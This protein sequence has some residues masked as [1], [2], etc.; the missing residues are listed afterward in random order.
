MT[1]IYAKLLLTAAFWGGTFIAGRVL[2][3]HAGPF[4]GS[5]LRFAVAGVLLVRVT[6]RSE[7]GLPAPPLLGE[8]LTASLLVGT[9]MVSAGVALTAVEPGRLRRSPPQV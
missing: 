9:V 1:L 3:E 2:T 5:F 8:P 6:V 4:A 7:N